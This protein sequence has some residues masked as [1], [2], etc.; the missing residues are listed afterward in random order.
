MTH[1]YTSIS[2]IAAGA[3]KMPQ[4]M[5]HEQLGDD[6]FDSKVAMSNDVL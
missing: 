1:S 6:A 3:T 4:S 2:S 5:A